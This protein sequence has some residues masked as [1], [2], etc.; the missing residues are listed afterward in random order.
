M[1]LSRFRNLKDQRILFLPLSNQCF[2]LWKSLIIQFKRGQVLMGKT[3][4]V[5]KHGQ[6]ALDMAEHTV[7]LWYAGVCASGTDHT[8]HVVRNYNV[9]ICTCVCVCLCQLLFCTCSMYNRI[10]QCVTMETPLQELCA[11]L[12]TCSRHRVKLH[13][14]N[15]TNLVK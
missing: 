2:I 10:A 12:E 15:T 5:L 8:P 6:T 14:G 3:L 1:F 11:F 4:A 7:Q 13:Y 9:C